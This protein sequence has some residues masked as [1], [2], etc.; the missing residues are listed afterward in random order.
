VALRAT[1]PGKGQARIKWEQHVKV[2]RDFL[3]NL[4]QWLRWML[5]MKDSVILL[6]NTGIWYNSKSEYHAAL[7]KVTALLLKL[8][9]VWQHHP[10]P[11]YIAIVFAET[12]SQHFLT[13]NG[14]YDKSI[15]RNTSKDAFC[16]PIN[17]T[18]NDWRNDILWNDFIRGPWGESLSAMSHVLLEVLPMHALTRD[19]ADLHVRQGHH[20]CTH[21]CYSPMLY[22]P[23]YSSLE[24]ISKTFLNLK[25]SDV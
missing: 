18:S 17:D 10:V 20:D 16:Q 14:Y 2:D 3:T 8:A 1:I 21:Y 4:E 11:K 22:Q 25:R 9:R 7:S 5:Q 6:V 12:S 13:P 19:L 24:R 15:H 23:I